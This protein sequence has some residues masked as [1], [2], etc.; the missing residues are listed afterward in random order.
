MECGTPPF[1]RYLPAMSESLSPE[2]TEGF[3]QAADGTRIYW[4]VTGH[5]GPALVCC[6]GVGCDGFVWKYLVR[7]FSPTHR[8]VRWHYRGHGRSGLPADRSR[9]TFDDICDD[10]SAVLDATN[11]KTA[12]LVG[13]SMG[14][15]VA[16]EYHKRFPRLVLGLVLVC[17]SAGLLLDTFHDSRMLKTVFPSLLSAADKWP[18]ATDLLWR[19]IAGG[20]WAYQIATHLEVNGKLVRREDFTP[21]FKHLAGMDPRLF[22]GM[23]KHASEHTAE[24]HL[25]SVDVPVLI[26]AGTHDTFTPYWLSQQMYDRIPGAEMLTVPGGSHI[27][28]LEQPELITLRL[29]KWLAGVHAEGLRVAG[30]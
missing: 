16:L 19:M 13:H 9:V 27:A 7:D 28:P 4:S 6:D 24:S 21:Y 1:L 23:L 14:V 3:A 26:V 20:E 11:T 18:E 17:G 25:G 22:L 2:T 15:Q 8:I 29:E 5:G 30:S 10:L 12:V